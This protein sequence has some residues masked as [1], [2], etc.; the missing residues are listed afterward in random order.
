MAIR[1]W[2]L[3]NTIISEITIVNSWKYIEAKYNPA[4]DASRGINCDK[5]TEKDRWFQGPE[6]LWK[7]LTEQPNENLIDIS[8]DDP[9]VK[10]VRATLTIEINPKASI[11][12]RIS[13]WTKAKKVIAYCLRFIWN[14]RCKKVRS[15][16]MTVEEL[17]DSETA[18]FKVAQADEFN[19]EI[20]NL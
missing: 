7:A 1:R 20:M 12:A 17:I 14:V 15:G 9:E 11:I 2:P 8:E 10:K 4:D 5:V 16:P 19:K 6:F 13:K 18:L 3:D